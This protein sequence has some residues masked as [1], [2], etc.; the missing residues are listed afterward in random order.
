MAEINAAEVPQKNPPQPNNIKQSDN[1]KKYSAILSK[2]FVEAAPAQEADAWELPFSVGNRS[3]I[4]KIK[5]VGEYGDYRSSRL[6]GHRH[7]GV[8]IVP[9][10]KSAPLEV[11]PAAKGVVCFITQQEPVKTVIIKHRL[12]DGSTLYTA[13]IHLKDIFIENGQNVDE[14]TKIG[15]L[16]TKKE[17][18]AL[19]GNF[20]HLHFEVKKRID[21]Y[22]CASWLCMSRAELDEYF[23]SPRAFFKTHLK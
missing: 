13:Y 7:S 6:A 15:V 22:S 23:I 17:A 5:F 4:S 2:F 9:A 8:D 16:Y 3:E 14:G 11:Y 19:G 18:L 10:D 20:D 12:K 1:I 21:D